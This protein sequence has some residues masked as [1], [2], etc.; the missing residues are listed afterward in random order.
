MLNA[1]SRTPTR[2]RHVSP[3][4]TLSFRYLA[5]LSSGDTSCGFSIESRRGV[6]GPPVPEPSLT[7]VR[8]ASAVRA[9]RIRLRPARS[10]PVGTTCPHWGRFPEVHSDS[11]EAITPVEPRVFLSPVGTVRCTEPGKR[12]CP[13]WGHIASAVPTN[14]LSRSPTRGNHVSPL[15]TLSFRFLVALSPLGTLQVVRASAT[16]P[17]PLADASSLHCPTEDTCSAQPIRA[18]PE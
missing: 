4:G 10:P 14:G 1:L 16:W 18:R 11:H 12:E 8:Y 17:S 13:H 15:E 3:L 6:T 2:R 9:P 5:A 7:L